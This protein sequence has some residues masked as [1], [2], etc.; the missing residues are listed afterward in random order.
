MSVS[1]TRFFISNTFISDARLELIKI[2]QMLSNTLRLNFW[3]LKIVHILHPR[4]HPEIIGHIPKNKQ[5]NKFVCVH[6]I[7][8]LII[9]KMKMKMKTGSHIYN[10]NSP[11]S[12]HL[13]HIR[14]VSVWWCLYVL[15]NTWAKFEAQFMRKSRN[16][17]AELKKS[18]AY[19]KSV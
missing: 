2:K 16:T 12:R 7:I 9:A 13:V 19:K 11:R 6:E 8:W 17:E 3:Y 15:R 10:I 18:V 1:N 4:Y 14:S 5:N